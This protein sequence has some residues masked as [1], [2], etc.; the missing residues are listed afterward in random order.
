MIG[1]S[2]DGAV[3]VIELQRH[4]RRNALN[5]MLCQEVRAA[6]ESAVAGGARAVVVTG[7][8]TSFCAGADL[9]GDVYA[10]DFLP[11]LAAMLGSI[12]QAPVPVIAAVNGAAVGAGVMLALACDLRV[13]APQGRF[14]V[15]AAKLGVALDTWTIRR[16]AKIAGGGVA[17]QV[18]LGAETVLPEAA[19]RCG[20]ANRLGDLAAAQEWAHEIAGFAPL[21]LRHLKLVLNDDGAHAEPSPEQVAAHTAAWSSA[22]AAEARAAV[23]EKRR[24]EFT[25]E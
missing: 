23:A 3:A 25:G 24:P 8:G 14:L 6:V 15:P 16:L 5:T 12:E 10:E 19:L 1:S 21:T 20:L 7:E 4:E 2:N 9:T 13:V 22:D 17:R 11:S 18:L